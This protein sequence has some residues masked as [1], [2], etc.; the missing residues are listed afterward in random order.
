MVVK[1]RVAFKPRAILSF[2]EDDFRTEVQASLT[3]DER[4]KSVLIMAIDV[5]RNGGGSHPRIS[6]EIWI[7]I[8]ERYDHVFVG[9]KKF[10]PKGKNG[11]LVLEEVGK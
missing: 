11:R 9:V 7:E 1:A 8:R 10:Q 4:H 5:V 6:E 3:V 2:S